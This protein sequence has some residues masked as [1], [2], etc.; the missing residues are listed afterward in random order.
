MTELEIKAAVR[1]RDGYQ[2]TTCGLTDDEHQAIYGKT[3]D[4][5]RL[6]PGSVYALD[7]SCKTLC[8]SCH[9]HEPVHLEN[10]SP[11]TKFKPP[12]F[13]NRLSVPVRPGWIER[14]KKHAKALS[15]SAS[16]YIRMATN[17]FMQSD[18][19]PDES[20]AKRSRKRPKPDPSS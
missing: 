16:A 17:R 2:C 1:E 13:T 6:S 8:K 12:T 9:G 11:R 5:H 15:L 14:V 20:P 4:V 19:L 18:P 7:E 3:L 10:R